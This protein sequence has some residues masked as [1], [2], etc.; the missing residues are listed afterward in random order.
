M[1]QDKNKTIDR[2]SLMR[3]P[4]RAL[5]TK[6]RTYAAFEFDRILPLIDNLS[7]KRTI[8]DPM[9][10]YGTLAAI[11]IKRYSPISTFCIEPNPPE[12][13]WQI[14]NNPANNKYALHLCTNFLSAKNKWPQIKEIACISSD[15]LPTQSK[16][17]I[18]DLFN[19]AIRLTS[20]LRM[21]Q[22]LQ[23]EICISLLMPF[24]GRFSSCVQGNIVTHVKRGGIVVYKGW[25]IDFENYLCFLLNRLNQNRDFAIKGVHTSIFA[26]CITYKFKNKFS[27]MITSPPYPNSRD[28]AAMFGPENDILNLLNSLGKIDGLTLSSRLIGCPIVSEEDS[29]KKGKISDVKSSIARS[30][31]ESIDS[32]HGTDQA[33]YDNKVYYLPYFSNY[34]SD[35]EKAYS[36]IA[37]ALS[38]N[39]EG[40]VI[41]VNNTHRKKV[42]PVSQAIVEIWHNLG[43]K[44][45]LVNEYT[46]ELSHVGGIN[47]KVKGFT[48]RHIEYTIKVWNS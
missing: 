11:C 34:F 22:A 26:N 45:D 2:F 40:Y 39:F 23:Q 33:N 4:Y 35:L 38:N 47:P 12:Y 30:F 37:K 18:V 13:L 14:L 48:A 1:I 5:L 36:N 3:Q 43:F 44:A 25:E 15:W 19:L 6:G 8:L 42:V 7:S 31:L 9:S 16:E 27:A 29:T 24:L 46:R 17:I 20:D 28:Y 32:Y 10:G 21:K 41:A